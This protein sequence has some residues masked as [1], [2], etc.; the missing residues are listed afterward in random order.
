MQNVNDTSCLF[1]SRIIFQI[2]FQK[3]HRHQWRHTKRR[4]HEFKSISYI[5]DFQNTHKYRIMFIILSQYIPMESARCTYIKFHPSVLCEPLTIYVRFVPTPIIHKIVVRAQ[6]FTVAPHSFR[7]WKWFNNAVK[8]ELTWY[9]GGCYSRNIAPWH[10]NNVTKKHLRHSSTHLNAPSWY[11]LH[12]RVC[13]SA[14]FSSC[15]THIFSYLFLLSFEN[16]SWCAVHDNVV[17]CWWMMRS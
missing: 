3:Q 10:P 4:S 16:L 12:A 14:S 11:M 5:Y 1:S 17:K 2:L 9:W 15:A 13:I 7:N 6:I 8:L